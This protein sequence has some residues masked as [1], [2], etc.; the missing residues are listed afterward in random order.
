[1]SDLSA[2]KR[3]IIPDKDGRP[4][5]GLGPGT[6]YE[7]LRAYFPEAQE[8][9][10]IASAYFTTSGYKRA[11]KF[12]S[13]HVKLWILVGKED[14]RN[15]VQTVIEDI[16]ED[17]SHAE[18][19]LWEAIYD[20]VEKLRS[21]S[22]RIVDA[23]AMQVPFH[24]KFY[25]VDDKV[26]LHGSSNFSTR[27]LLQ[28]IEQAGAST[29]ADEIAEFTGGF[30][31]YYQTATPLTDSLIELLEDYLNLKHPF[32]IYLKTLLVLNKLPEH[33]MRESGYRPVY[34]QRAVVARMLRQ[35]DIW[36]SSIL[37]A[38]T[39]LGKTV[40]GA[41]VA[42]QMKVAGLIKRVIL[43]SPA[44]NVQAEW[45]RELDARDI[46]FHSFTNSIAFMKKAAKGDLKQ[47]ARLDEQLDRAD[48]ETLLIIDEAHLYR[49]QLLVKDR[50]GY[51]SRVID[52][53]S[54]LV[55]E[56]KARII[57]LTATP[58]STSIV[59]LNSLLALLPKSGL[60]NLWG[61]SQRHKIKHIS[62]F[63]RLPMCSVI[64]LPHVIRLAQK[65]GDVDEDGRI[66]IQYTDRRRYMPKT[67][68]M[69]TVT[70]KLST[71]DDF[72]TAWN[73]GCFN[74]LN[75][76]RQLV[77]NENATGDR[78]TMS[79]IID[80]IRNTTLEAWLSSPVAL[81][82]AVTKNLLTP[83][84]KAVNQ[85]LWEVDENPQKARKKEVLNGA[86]ILENETEPYNTF[87]KLPLK[88][89]KR[90]LV[91]LR[92][93]VASVEEN[94]QNDA[95]L[96]A[97]FEIIQERCMNGGKVLIFTTL[98]TTANY[99]KMALK[100]KFNK[101]KID[102]TVE[103]KSLKPIR[104]RQRMQRS[105]AP[106]ANR[107]A[108]DEQ[109]EL[110]VL[111]V[112]DA[113]GV[114]VNLQD[115]DTVISYDLPREA[116]KMIQRVGRVLRPTDE[117]ERQVHLYVLYPKSGIPDLEMKSVMNKVMERFSRV[118]RRHDSAQQ[119]LS[120]PVMPSLPMGARGDEEQ[121]IHLDRDVDVDA[122]LQNSDDILTQLSSDVDTSR[123]LQYQAVLEDARYKERAKTLND[124]ISSARYYS[125]N[126]TLV[127]VLVLDGNSGKHIPILY[128]QSTKGFVSIEETELLDLLECDDGTSPALLKAAEVE[129]VVNY[130]VRKWCKENEKDIGSVRKVCSMVL[131]PKGRDLREFLEMS[132]KDLDGIAAKD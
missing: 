110:D 15:V 117:K 84:P 55:N 122:L 42:F 81:R 62:E 75:P 102:A 36:R 69:R 6:A 39:G 56:K 126:E 71:D 64:G 119:I 7:L 34:Y 26:L 8:K 41:E 124:N 70:Y 112:T 116:D 11:R 120:S 31:Y 51:D 5:L 73:E 125:G 127:Y 72:I 24:C 18:E 111:I 90:Y 19:D 103:G 32:D 128:S 98:H 54:R 47:V 14:G 12:I 82:I 78:L 93:K 77:A 52:R 57:L 4:K 20:L 87:L 16:M 131:T 67:I 33:E 105:F 89:R 2:Q 25:I 115:A 107:A 49:N 65:R 80:F 113:D 95:K 48:Q 92:D 10:R 27:G 106:K 109:D 60:K 37:I 44:G 46:P 101:L 97:L 3:I 28:S 35:I 1:M 29:A 45:E 121:I 17:N 22:L 53:I 91:P 96:T 76:G 9:I 108:I 74:Q 99:L 21:G 130:V 58:Y 50:K 61:E 83:D 132:M 118:T 38:A 30:E 100:E 86:G 59:N 114:G 23:R 13:D 66:Y 129:R 79:A 68:Q 63:V 43:L 94:Y 88:E 123:A 40:M 85:V 104:E